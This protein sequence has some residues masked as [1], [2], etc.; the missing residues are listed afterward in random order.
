MSEFLSNTPSTTN[1]RQ[2]F[3]IENTPVR[4]DVVHLS[5]SYHQI[6]QQ[7]SYPIAL[8]KLLGEMLVSASLLIGT[9]KIDGRLSIQLQHNDITNDGTPEL[10]WAMAEC[11][12]RG[13]IRGLA[14]WTGDWNNLHTA[15]QAFSTLGA[16][17]EGVLFINVQPDPMFGVQ[18]EGYQGI[19]ERVADNLAD[20]LAH[21]QKQSVQIPTLINLACDGEQ[22]GGI[23]VQLLPV[24]DEEEKASVDADLFPRLTMLTKTLK[25][26]ELTSLEPTE[27]LYRLY[28]EEDVVTAEPVPLAFA[29][30]CSREKTASAIF[31][32]GENQA[33][34]IADEQGG[35]LA[36]DCGFCGSVYRFDKQDIEAVFG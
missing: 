10:K 27:I 6:T 30:T 31:Q 15:N 2:R 18:A 13:H 22:A 24:L 5:D 11:D 23:L 4:G 14:D 28:H 16:V 7:K 33:L 9:L 3:F 25:A 34:E 35:A 32:L 8:Q 1:L 36:L 19:V 17:G 26:E 21:Y 12:S 29:C 20:C